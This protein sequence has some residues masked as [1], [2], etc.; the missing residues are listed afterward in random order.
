MQVFQQ[1]I[2]QH[3]IV[4]GGLHDRGN[5]AQSRQLRRTPTPFTHN[6]FI[7]GVA[8]RILAGIMRGRFTTG[9]C[10]ANGFHR[11]LAHHDGLQHTN[12]GDGRRQ[13][14]QLILVEDG[15]RLML[16]GADIRNIELIEVSAQYRLQLRFFLGLCFM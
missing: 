1:R 16:V 7:R 5:R 12:F 8:A 15:T 11:T 13:L 2:T 10:G 9:R 14:V 3:V 4:G 6:Q